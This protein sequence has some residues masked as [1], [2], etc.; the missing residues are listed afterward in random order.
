M[1]DGRVLSLCN[2]P[3]PSLEAQAWEPHY[4]KFSLVLGT[5]NCSDVERVARACRHHFGP[6]G[7]PA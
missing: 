2:N 1:D 4:L 3:S 6:C 7:V 5:A